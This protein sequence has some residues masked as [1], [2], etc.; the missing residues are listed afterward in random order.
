[1]VISMLVAAGC[2][3]ST[4]LKPTGTVGNR[5]TTQAS[6]PR[7]S[8]TS[9]GVVVKA[10]TICRRVNN[11][12]AAAPPGVLASQ[13]ARSAPRNAAVEQRAIAELNGITPPTAVASDWRKMIA[14]RQ[15]LAEELLKLANYAKVN[16]TR[17]MQALAVSKERVHQ[18]LSALATRDG[19]KDCAQLSASRSIGQA[20]RSL[21][22]GQPKGTPE[23]L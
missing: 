2:G 10:D 17:S 13:I 9:S 8:S 3:D 22:L 20:L 21:R 4:A 1:M 11:E 19:F 23:K 15:T 18:K 14:Y 6:A 7:G 12:L 16:D 5:A